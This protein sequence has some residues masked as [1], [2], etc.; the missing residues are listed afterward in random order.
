MFLLPPQSRGFTHPA[1]EPIFSIAFPDDRSVDHEAD[2][3]VGALAGAKAALKEEFEGFE[4]DEIPKGEL[5]GL[6]VSLFNAS[7]GN[8]EDGKFT[9]NC[10]LFVPEEGGTCFLL[11]FIACKEG[12]EKHGYALNAIL[13]PMK[14][15]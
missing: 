6:N 15:G 8:D 4:V 3:A 10:A 13:N 9:M 12:L 2:E 11:L 5:N 7:A 1:D 14:A